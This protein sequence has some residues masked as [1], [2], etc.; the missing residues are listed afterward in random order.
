MEVLLATQQ[1]RAPVVYGERVLRP[2]VLAPVSEP[3]AGSGERALRMLMLAPA[4][5]REQLRGRTARRSTLR[6]PRRLSAQQRSG[7]VGVVLGTGL[8]RR[9]ELES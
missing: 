1:L 4:P 3:R 9:T 6:T 5:E 8:D 2:L 7:G